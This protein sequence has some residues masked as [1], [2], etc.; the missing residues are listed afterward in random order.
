MFAEKIFSLSKIEFLVSIAIINISMVIVLGIL[1]EPRSKARDAI[2]KYDMGQVSSAQ[3]IYNGNNEKYY[4]QGVK[5]RK[6]TPEIE[7]YLQILN[8]PLCPSGFCEKGHP[9]YNWEA[10]DVSIDCID[11]KFDASKGQWFCVWAELENNN[12]CSERA[13]CSASSAGVMI[14]CDTAPTISGDCTCLH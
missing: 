6:G 2:R 8:D 4:V 10:N 1:I 3:E 12:Y 5:I 7:P 9:N 13:Y 11:N 14:V